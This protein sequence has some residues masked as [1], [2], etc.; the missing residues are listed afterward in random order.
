MDLQDY[1]QFNPSELHADYVSRLHTNRD[2][3]AGLVN[4]MRQKREV[5][6]KP[7]CIN[8]S[9]HQFIYA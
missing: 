1:A 7:L 4:L 3:E 8:S 2:M 6:I 5:Q 9:M